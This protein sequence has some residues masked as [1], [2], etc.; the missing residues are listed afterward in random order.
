[1]RKSLLALV[2]LFLT[3]AAAPAADV[4]LL[5]F[6]PEQK[7]VTV[8]EGEERRTYKI[9]EATK[10]YGVDPDGNAREMTYADAVKG[11]GNPKSKNELTFSLEAKADEITEARFRARKRM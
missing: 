3:A 6:D 1:M 8:R 9:T 10:F 2:C 7:A 4:T 5:D 11:L